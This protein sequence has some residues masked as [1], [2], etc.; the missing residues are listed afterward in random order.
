M[1]KFVVV[2]G[3]VGLLYSSGRTDNRCQKVQYQVS[4]SKRVP[5]P[6]PELG[7]R[8]GFIESS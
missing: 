7:Q 4:L 8:L 2:V 5:E 6:D 1:M 3:V